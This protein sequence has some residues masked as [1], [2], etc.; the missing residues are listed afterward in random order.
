MGEGP[1]GKIRIE[2]AESF[3]QSELNPLEKFQACRAVVWT[4]KSARCEHFDHNSRAIFQFS[5]MAVGYED[6]RGAGRPTSNSYNVSVKS[7]HCLWSSVLMMSIF[8]E[9]GCRSRLEMRRL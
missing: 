7:I 5:F 3:L 9:P 1:G 4:G 2:E 8:Q 6:A